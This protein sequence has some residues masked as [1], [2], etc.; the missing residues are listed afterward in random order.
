MGEVGWGGVGVLKTAS[1]CELGESDD[2]LGGGGSFDVRSTRVAGIP[3][4]CNYVASLLNVK[5]ILYWL[6]RMI[7]VISGRL[8]P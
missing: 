3:H 1:R 6:I 2:W 8:V 4:H 5:W 7:H